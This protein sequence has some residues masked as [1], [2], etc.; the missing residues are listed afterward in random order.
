MSWLHELK[1]K[2]R[3]SHYVYQTRCVRLRESPDCCVDFSSMDSDAIVL[4]FEQMVDD[5][6]DAEGSDHPPKCDLIAIQGTASR[7]DVVLVEVKAGTSEYPPDPEKALCKA[8][9]Q[10]R[11]SLHIVRDELENCKIHPSAQV[12]HHAVAVLSSAGQVTFVRDR[13]PQFLAEFSRDTGGI[14]L[15][16]ALCGDDIRQRI[17]AGQS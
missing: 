9:T 12:N 6:A 2:Y 4:N 1:L 10:L 3:T 16:V 15:T 14:Q 17:G 13:L 8:M 5:R 11:T 7:V